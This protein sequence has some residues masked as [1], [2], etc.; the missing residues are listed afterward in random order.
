MQR[1]TYKLHTAQDRARIVATANRGEDWV[2]LAK[3][4]CINY[5]TAYGWVNSGRSD[6]PGR[7]GYKPKKLTENQIDIVMQWVEEN[8]TITLVEMQSR[9]L[10]DFRQ[11]LCLST[12]SNYLEGRIFTTKSVHTQPSTMNTIQNKEKRRTYVTTLMEHM[13]IGKQIAYIDE[14]NFNL[15]CRRNR[16]RAR[17]GTRAVQILPPGR[18][19][20]IHLIG[21]ITSYGI[22]S[23]ERRRGS[24]KAE[25]ANEWLVAVLQRWVEMGNHLGDLVIVCDN[26][27][28][29]AR[30]ETAIN[31]FQGTEKATLLRLGPYS[32]MLNPIENIWSKIKTFVKGHIG[33]PTTTGPGVIDQR[34]VYLEQLVDQAK[35]TITGGDCSQAIQHCST[36]YSDVLANIDMPVGV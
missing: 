31:N 30:L 4:L 27:P 23:M 7:G 20:N 26:A 28:C 33:I 3:S 8:C 18:G 36:F 16:G 29:H 13:R 10:Q 14:T 19:R 12:I 15:F 22:L 24:F 6:G 1:K 34:M 5:K 35:A 2:S 11:T 21:A 17:A 32:P 25:D 9:I